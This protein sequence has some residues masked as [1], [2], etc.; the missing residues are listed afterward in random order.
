LCPGYP[1]PLEEGI[2]Q[3]LAR[4]TI[5]NGFLMD[6]FGDGKNLVKKM[7]EKFGVKQRKEKS[8]RKEN[9]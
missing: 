9:A 7:E 2:L 3:M 4:V 5:N 1:Y 6:S 8:K